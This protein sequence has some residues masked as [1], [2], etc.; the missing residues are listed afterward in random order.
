MARVDEAKPQTPWWVKGIGP[1]LKIEKW[2]GDDDEYDHRYPI[3]TLVLSIDDEG[4]QCVEV[5]EGKLEDGVDERLIGPNAFA[6]WLDQI[7]PDLPFSW[8]GEEQ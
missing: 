8:K 3:M 6:E 5:W 4:F 7:I 1:A 2:N